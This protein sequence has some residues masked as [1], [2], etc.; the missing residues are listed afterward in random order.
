MTV[1]GEPLEAHSID[2][3]RVEGESVATADGLDQLGVGRGER[4]PEADH[5]GLHGLGG[6]RRGILAPQ[7]I[8]DRV[9]GHHASGAAGE[10]GQQAAPVGAGHVHLAAVGV[11]RERPEHRDANVSARSGR[12][13]APFPEPDVLGHLP[14]HV[15]TLVA[16]G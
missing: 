3:R 5:V 12:P 7:R 14:P 2:R 8:D 9:H 11:D 4:A 13:F 1:G 15:P 16:A 6:R 10:Q